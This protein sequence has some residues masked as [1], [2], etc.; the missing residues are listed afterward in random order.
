MKEK[1]YDPA[2][3]NEESPAKGMASV[4]SFTPDEEKLVDQQEKDNYS[5]EEEIQNTKK[6]GSNDTDS[7]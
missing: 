6:I 2:G 4:N 7:V 5:N 3:K 1:Q